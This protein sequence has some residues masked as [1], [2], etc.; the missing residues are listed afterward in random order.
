M[1]TLRVMTFNVRGFY[2]PDDGVN[3]W[4]H[5][6][7]LNVATVQS[8]APHLIGMQEVQTGN[9]KAYHR[10]LPEY[11]WLAW[12][13]YGNAPPY[14]WP[15]LYWDPGAITPIDNGGFWLSETPDRFSGSWDTDCIRA[16]TWIKFQHAAT[17]ASVVH[18]N[19][20][21]DHIS[22]QAR[23]EGSRLILARLGELQSDGSA[24]IV[25]AD[26]NARPE[27][28]THRLYTS[29]GF[30]DAYLAAGHADHSER[31]FT[32]HGW[33]GEAFRREGPPVRID[34]IL[35][36]DGARWRAAVRSCEIVRDAEPPVYPS[37]HYPVVADLELSPQETA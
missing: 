20:H 10:G 16:A 4:Q 30:S 23:I 13:E 2:H 36:R 8:T 34:W 26:F 27:S 11:H 12:P 1:S 5:R 15:A 17:G 28:A 25:T 37:D 18:L 33:R 24:A 14:E 32:F 29:A 35:V 3:Q 22:E 6:E 31:S 21:L 9:L 7:A 19:T